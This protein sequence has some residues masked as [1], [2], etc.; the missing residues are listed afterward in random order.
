MTDSE[1]DIIRTILLDDIPLSEND[2]TNIICPYDWM[3]NR[4]EVIF[5]NIV[6][7]SSYPQYYIKFTVIRSDFKVFI[8][9]EH[10]MGDIQDRGLIGKK[11]VR[12]IYDAS[13][14]ILNITPRIIMSEP[15]LQNN[16]GY[17]ELK[18][19]PQETTIENWF[20]AEYNKDIMNRKLLLCNKN[21]YNE[22]IQEI[23]NL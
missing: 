5:Y 8:G 10:M 6:F 17:Y 22:F 3:D 23:R 11:I 19:R 21:V 7:G 4:I 2:T 15:I 18:F 12:N 13:C 16:R 9:S 1:L 20:D 14:T